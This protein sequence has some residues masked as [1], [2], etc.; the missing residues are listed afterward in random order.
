MAAKAK[1]SP[2]EQKQARDRWDRLTKE[3]GDAL[4]NGAQAFSADWLSKNGIGLDECMRLGSR[5]GLILKGFV[6]AS[7]ETQ[8]IILLLGAVDGEKD[9][10]LAAFRESVEGSCKL[11]G[12][13]NRLLAACRDARKKG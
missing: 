9:I 2:E 12:A 3:I 6:N 8:R 5:A 13:R 4:Q 11:E 7:P 10:N 1:K